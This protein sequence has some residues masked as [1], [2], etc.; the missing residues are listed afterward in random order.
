MDTLDLK[1]LGFVIYLGL[2]I[3]QLQKYCLLSVHGMWQSAI[4]LQNLLSA[5]NNQSALTR[6]YIN[7]FEKGTSFHEL[8]YFTAFWRRKLNINWNGQPFARMV[9]MKTKISI[10]NVKKQCSSHGTFSCFFLNTGSDS[11]IYWLGKYTFF[12]GFIMSKNRRDCVQNFQLGEKISKPFQHSFVLTQW[13][14]GRKN[15]Y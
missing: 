7:G 8:W 13:N 11:I 14:P 15:I 3:H 5:C 6:L 2:C 12:L 1:R 9:F 10:L 4:F